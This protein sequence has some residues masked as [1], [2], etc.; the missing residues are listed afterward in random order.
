MKR[1]ILNK[2]LVWIDRH[3]LHSTL[4]YLRINDRICFTY[5]PLLLWSLCSSLPLFLPLIG[6]N[7]SH[8]TCLAF[9]TATHSKLFST[10]LGL[11]FALKVSF[12]HSLNFIS[13]WVNL[14]IVLLACF[15]LNQ[16]PWTQLTLYFRS[17]IFHLMYFALHVRLALL[18]ILGLRYGCKN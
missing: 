2:D 6:S 15:L 10:F 11:L 16:S 3:Y 9:F 8:F 17:K 14:L 4:K 18:K 5:L 12:Y 13:Y 7:L 1:L